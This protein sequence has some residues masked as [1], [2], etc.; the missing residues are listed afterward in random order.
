MGRVCVIVWVG[1]GVFG[2]QFFRKVLMDVGGWNTRFCMNRCM[3][4]YEA[5]EEVEGR[6]NMSS[7]F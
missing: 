2:I 4:E 6:V 3:N 1:V 7:W 5:F